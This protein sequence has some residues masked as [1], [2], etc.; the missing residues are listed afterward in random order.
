VATRADNPKTIE[1]DLAVLSTGKGADVLGR[2]IRDCKTGWGHRRRLGVKHS[3][4][5]D[6]RPRAFWTQ[7]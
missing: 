5:R 1:V 6:G 3:G 2:V 4:M 7:C